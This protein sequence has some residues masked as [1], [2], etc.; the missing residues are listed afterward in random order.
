M[1]MDAGKAR[2]ARKMNRARVLKQAQSG[3]LTHKEIA[4]ANG[5]SESTVWKFLYRSKPEIQAVESFKAHRADVYTAFQAKCLDLQTKIIE[6]LE[7]DAVIGALKVSEK[8]SLLFAL[9]ATHGTS[10]D[11]ERLERGLS[12]ENHSIVSKLL[13]QR[14]Q[15]RYKPAKQEKKHAAAQAEPASTE[16]VTT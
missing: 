6:S 12:T 9:N 13:D 4:Q 5:V 16:S 3:A 8:S 10:Y 14:V 11:K 2:D 1:T 15:A 7:G